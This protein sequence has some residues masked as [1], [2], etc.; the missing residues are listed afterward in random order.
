MSTW[1]VV[2]SP[3]NFEIAKSRGFDMFGF[4]DKRKRESASMAVGD[5]LIFYLIGIMKFGGTAEVDRRR[6]RGRLAGVQDREE[7]G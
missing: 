6:L 5:K 1:I 4:K 3:E 7:A 2:G